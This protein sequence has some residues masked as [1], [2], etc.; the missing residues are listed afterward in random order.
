[1]G[2]TSK[3]LPTS[4]HA[5]RIA[6]DAAERGSMDVARFWLDVAR[7]LR[8]GSAPAP[9]TGGILPGG[10]RVFVGEDD[11]IRPLNP[12][13]S[14]DVTGPGS[15]HQAEVTDA[16]RRA[17]GSLF[18]GPDPAGD[19]W[20]PDVPGYYVSPVVLGTEAGRTAVKD[21]LAGKPVYTGK[22]EPARAVELGPGA[23]RWD[24]VVAEFDRGQHD[25]RQDALTMPREFLPTAA[26]A[27]IPVPAQ[28]PAE[29]TR[30]DLQRPLTQPLPFVPQPEA[31]SVATCRCSEEI[32]AAVQPDP[33]GE[34]GPGLKTWRH[35]RTGLA[36]CQPSQ[37]STPTPGSYR[38]ATPA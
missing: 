2:E 13:P 24:S 23:K 6:L 12:A 14:I 31:I 32:Y 30:L 33:E 20:V 3:P 19:E 37:G 22:G 4:A 36:T 7:E 21:A 27:Q 28:R 8:E 18:S 25:P 17:E 10:A 1:M 9:A 29:E 11:V 38:F 34:A 15:P 5:M 35:R 16:V 26:N